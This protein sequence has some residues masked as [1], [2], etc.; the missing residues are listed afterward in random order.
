VCICSKTL[1]SK[2]A[3]E[4]IV[5]VQIPDVDVDA[6]LV[7][8]GIV[9]IRTVRPADA[10]ALLGMYDRVSVDALHM[11]FFSVSDADSRRDVE[12]MTRPPSDDHGSMLAQIGDEVVGVASFERLDDDPTGAEFAVLVDDAQHGRGVGT[13]LL[14]HLSALA[15]SSGVNRFAAEVL[16]TNAAML[17]L[18]RDAGLPTV[19][20]RGTSVVHVELPLQFDEYFRR[21]VG[22]RESRADATSLARILAPASV[23]VVG[24]GVDP[25]GLGH[26]VLANIVRGGYRGALHAVNR[27]GHRVAGIRAQRSL[28]DVPQPVDVVVIAVPASEV[29]GIVN[30]AAACGAAGVVVV[31]AGFAELGSAGQLRQDAL[32]RACRSAGLRLIGPNCS[33]IA[34]ADPAIALNA[35]LSPRMP[36]AGG[37]GLMAQSGAVG[38][39]ALAYAARVGVGISSFI[40]AG[41]KADVSGNDLLCAWEADPATRVCALYLES[42]GNPRKFAQIAARAGRSKP[43]VVVKSGRTERVSHGGA[44]GLSTTATAD[45][46]AA[47]LFEQAGVTRVESLAEMFDVASLFDLAALPN[48]RHVAIVANGAGPGLLAADACHA[49]GL[50]VVALN[51]VT[52]RRLTGLLPAGGAIGNPVDLHAAADPVSFEAALRVLLDDGDIDA[53]IAVYAPTQSGLGGAFARAITTV[54]ADVDTKPLLA[55]FLG[56]VDAPAELRSASDRLIVPYFAFPEPAAKALGAVVRYATW[57]QLPTGSEREFHDIDLTVARAIVSK[58][59]SG[60]PDDRWLDA[61]DAAALVASYGVTVIRNVVSSSAAEAASAASSLGYPVALKVAAGAITDKS[62][63][64]GLRLNLRSAKDVAGAYEAMEERLGDVMTN[65]IVQ[66]MAPA[67]VEMAIGVVADSKFGS[68]VTVG[69]GGMLGDLIADRVFH[70]LPMSAEAAARQVRSLRTTPLLF[71]Y[72]GTPVSD[73]AALEEM[74][75]R[76][77]AMATDIPELAELEMNPVIVTAD[78]AVA[79]DVKVRLRSAPAPTDALSR[80]LS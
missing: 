33:G 52:Q 68:V 55:C 34:N 20:Q 11:R 80:N 28:A 31:S 47:T 53:V 45:I 61:E 71:G 66:P 32:V 62:G 8:A 17:H 60:S 58:A 78:G 6:L 1:A 69:L 64:G 9:R 77:A 2:D 10:A 49:S 27:S 79:V 56:V 63:R 40:S 73:V 57:R 29:L 51:S 36:S 39:A 50:D 5:T 37:V 35:T 25:A 26:Q 24:A 7:D 67:G 22:I 59:L 19:K 23:V 54:C 42:L 4:E 44:L 43:V 14:E 18:F 70:L 15:V 12:R 72:R 75:L 65:A 16:P 3:F 13:L 21:A 46:A 74:V 48:G 30:E 41:N 76:V 38:T